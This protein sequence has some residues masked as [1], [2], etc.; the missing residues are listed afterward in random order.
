MFWSYVFLVPTH[1]YESTYELH[2]WNDITLLESNEF[3]NTLRPRQ[4]GRHFANDISSYI[5]LNEN[6]WIS[7]DILLKYVP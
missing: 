6:F 3:I 4:N 2:F 7:N 1:R 5:F